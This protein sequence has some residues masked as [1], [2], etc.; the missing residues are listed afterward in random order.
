MSS[1]MHTNTKRILTKKLMMSLLAVCT[2]L[3]FTN[4]PAFAASTSVLL[5]PNSSSSPKHSQPTA[6]TMFSSLA[7]DAQCQGDDKSCV[8]PAGSTKCGQDQA[9]GGSLTGCASGVSNCNLLTKYLNPLITLLSVVVGIAVVIGLIVGGIQYSSSGGDP[10]KVAKAKLH[11]RNSLLALL[12]FFFL[13]AF[14]KFLVPG[15]N[16]LLQG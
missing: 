12:A 16:G 10:Q 7:D 3:V 13:Y 14:I 5:D 15:G 2:L 1:I 9:V 11:I 8:C 4:T 6:L